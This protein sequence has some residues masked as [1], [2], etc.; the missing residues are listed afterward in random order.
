M[1]T[2]KQY[3][4]EATSTE[5]STALETVLG[6]CFKAASQSSTSKGEDVLKGYMNDTKGPFNKADKY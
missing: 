3:L 4:A 2:F 6:A 1:Y 5:V